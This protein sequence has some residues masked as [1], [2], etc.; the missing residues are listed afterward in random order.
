MK[1][2]ASAEKK[3]KSSGSSSK[4]PA[5]SF[6]V[7]VKNRHYPASLEIRKLYRIIAD[8]SAAR[9]GMVRVVDESGEDYLYPADYFVPVKLPES[10]VRAVRS[11]S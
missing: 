6:A 1:H 7:C 5:P 9:L 8:R 10:V 3:S 11:V 2:M 4:R